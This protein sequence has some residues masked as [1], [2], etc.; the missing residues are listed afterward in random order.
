[1]SELSRHWANAGH[2]ITVLTGFPNHPTGRLHPEYRARFRRLTATERVGGVKVVRTWLLPLPNRKP[3]ERILNYTSFCVS[4]AI[5][6]LF[7]SRPE[8]I[9]GTSPQLLVGLAGWFLAKVKRVPFVFEV[10]DIWPDA[11]LAS[12]VGREGSLFARCLTAISRFLHKRSD[13]IVAVTPAFVEELAGRW[14]VP[15]A[16]MAVVV[17]GVE[18]SL[19]SP[20][21]STASVDDLGLQGRF[22]VS[23]VGTVGQAHGLATILEAASLLRERLPQALFLVVGEGAEKADLERRAADLALDNVRFTGHIP[24]ERIPDVIRSSDL[25]LVLLKDAPIFRTVIP[26]KMLEFMS[27]GRPILIGVDGQARAIVEGAGAGVFVPPEDGVALAA[28]VERLSADATLRRTLGEAGRS[29]IEREMTR[30]QTAR[31]YLSLLASLR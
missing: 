3:R 18:E 14:G 1:M 28:Q 27:C 17:N 16:K 6:G 22:V 7:L 11:I 24:R 19:F 23:Y 15:R 13:L 29:F 20:Q 8:V 26:T 25:C 30:E 2:E 21:G 4:A 31:K 10:R 5:R 12:G 9:I